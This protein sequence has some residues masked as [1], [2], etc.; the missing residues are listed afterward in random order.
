[1]RSTIRPPP[2]KLF[3][4]NNVSPVANHE[5]VIP[6]HR[7]I[8]RLAIPVM[9]SNVSTPLIGVVDTAIVGRIPDA[10]YIGAV[11]VASLVFTFLF[12]AFGFLR[13]GTTGLTAQASGAGDGAEVIASLGRA[14]LVAG[15]AGALLIILQWP[16]R[17]FAFG[18]IHGSDRVETLAREFFDIRIWSAPAALANYALL[19]WF[20][21]LGRTDVALVL[22]LILNL[23][24][25]ALDALFVLGFDW[26]VRGV[27]LGTLLAELIAAT[28]GIIIALRY[29]NRRK[30]RFNWQQIVQIERLK[31]TVS[32]N[33]DIM[34]R[35]LALML[36]FIWF[37][38]QGARE[39]DV[40]LAANAVLMQF[41]GVSAYFL[42]GLAFS[43]E[44]LV[45]RAIGAGHRAALIVSIRRTTLWAVALAAALSLA[46]AVNGSWAIDA[47]TTNDPVRQ[48]AKAYLPWAAVGPILGVW[49]FQ[50]DGV[51]I[52]ATRTA[53][54]RNAML[55]SLAIFFI[56]WRVTLP[57]GNTGLWATLCVHYL[58]RTTTLL[59]YYPRLV[60]GVISPSSARTVLP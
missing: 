17:E 46:I 24:N 47:F 41:V 22:Q 55:V 25:I 9:L 20:I 15:V 8:L 56:A 23:C 14:L 21:G 57:W 30:Q 51:F 19:G 29:A 32:V 39:G 5:G 11:A 16:L 35:S 49:A 34:V 43:A 6:S 33:S 27:A 36:A 58:A 45:G 60:R 42:D 31:R 1:V 7:A 54:M 13:M 53:E 59:Y 18:L 44:T 40:V 10:A 37:M 2:V 50:L 28:S 26:G 3:A 38:A 52:G 48:M 4:S 12:W